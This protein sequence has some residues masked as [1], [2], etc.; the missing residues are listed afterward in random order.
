[1]TRRAL[2][3]ALVGMPFV[4]ASIAQRIDHPMPDDLEE[5]IRQ[6]REAKRRRYQP[7]AGEDADRLIEECIGHVRRIRC[8]LRP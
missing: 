6:L 7:D 5:A 8:G 2:F 4:S 3:A 1:M